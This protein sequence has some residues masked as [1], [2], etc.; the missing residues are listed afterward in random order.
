M[1]ITAYQARNIVSSHDVISKGLVVGLLG[2]VEAYAQ[3]KRAW[4]PK[5]KCGG[6]NETA[7]F[8]DVEAQALEAIQ[9]LSSDDISRLKTYLGVKDLWINTSVPGKPSELKQLK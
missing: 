8:A 7:F 5:A 3:R 1:T 4:V 9:N 2:A 6:C